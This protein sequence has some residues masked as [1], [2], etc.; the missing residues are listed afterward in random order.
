MCKCIEEAKNILGKL[1][2]EYKKIPMPW[3]RFKM[4]IIIELIEHL[5]KLPEDDDGWISV[6]DWLPDDLWEP[7]LVI[8]KEKNMWVQNM[9]AVR[10]SIT[11]YKPLPNPPIT[12]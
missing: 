1:K 7:V 4:D 11:H 5:E 3:Y 10:E 9:S 2:I 12:K 6:A 8:S